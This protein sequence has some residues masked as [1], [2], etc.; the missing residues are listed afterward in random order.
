MVTDGKG[1][2]AIASTQGEFTIGFGAALKSAGTKGLGATTITRAG[3]V[4]GAM[5]KGFDTGDNVTGL[6]K[7]VGE[8]V[9]VIQTAITT[10]TTSVPGKMGAA[11]PDNGTVKTTT[12]TT[13][14]KTG[15]P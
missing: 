15:Q 8:V 2:Y 4:K 1:N 7:I 6:S 11:A 13:T 5:L 9:P 10:T 14:T 12:T 3:D